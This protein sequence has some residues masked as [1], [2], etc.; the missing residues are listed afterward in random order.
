MNRRNKAWLSI[1]ASI[2]AIVAI[3][4]SCGGLSGS[5]QSPEPMTG[6]AG[7]WQDPKIGI[8][9][10]ISWDGE[11]YNVT[12][13][14]LATGSSYP[15]SDIIWNGKILQWTYFDR[16]YN[17]SVIIMVNS[18][19]GDQAQAWYAQ[20]PNSGYLTFYRYQP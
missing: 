10:T 19:D 3:A 6:L 18:V 20:G 7:R 15:V 14:G 4:C 2:T 5:T 11:R 13:T 17:V 9:H 1:I 8:L 12:S 16:Q